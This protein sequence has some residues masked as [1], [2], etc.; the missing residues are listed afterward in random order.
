MLPQEM[1]KI[2]PLKWAEIAFPVLYEIRSGHQSLK[3]N[4]LKR[5][6]SLPELLKSAQPSEETGEPNGTPIHM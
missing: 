5:R 2:K 4:L 1:L 3:K 6:Q